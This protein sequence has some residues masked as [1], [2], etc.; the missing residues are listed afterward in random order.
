MKE[1]KSYIRYNVLSPDGFSLYRD[2]E[3]IKEKNAIIA[4]KKWVKRYKSQGYYSTIKNGARVQI[5]LN[6]ILDY[7]QVMEYTMLKGKCINIKML[8]HLTYENIG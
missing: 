1:I 8:Y 5:P 7:C 4:A 6:E 2:R 3:F